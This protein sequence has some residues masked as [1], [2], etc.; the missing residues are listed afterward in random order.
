M[1]FDNIYNERKAFIFIYFYLFLF[2]IVIVLVIT[3]IKYYCN[4]Y[5]VINWRKNVCRR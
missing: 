4:I 5:N 1:K 2:M 3:I